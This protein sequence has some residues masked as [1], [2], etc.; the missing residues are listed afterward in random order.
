MDLNGYK[1]DDGKSSSNLSSALNNLDSLSSKNPNVRGNIPKLYH[2]TSVNFC[3][4]SSNAH[5][6]NSNALRFRSS[7]Q[8]SFLNTSINSSLDFPTYIP[9]QSL[10]TEVSE[11]LKS[12]ALRINKR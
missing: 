5:M 2:S 3:N 4:N 11:N 9:W 6:T 10:S 12:G 1:N 8:N 7:R